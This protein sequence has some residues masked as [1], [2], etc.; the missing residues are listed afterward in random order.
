MMKPAEHVEA[1]ST[2]LLPVDA[3]APTR[4][5]TATFGLG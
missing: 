5:E 2:R 4:V 1:P 3:I